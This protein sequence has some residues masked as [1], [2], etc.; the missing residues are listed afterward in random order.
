MTGQP[1]PRPPVT[2]LPADD[3]FTA[4]ETSRRGLSRA[5][6]EDRPRTHGVNGLPR[7]APRAVG[8]QP[9]AQFT[10]LFAVMLLAASGITFL[11]YALEE[12]RDAG[13]LTLAVAILGVVGLNAAIGFAQEY[14]A[15]RTAQALEAMVPHTCRVLRDGRSSATAGPPCR[16]RRCVCGPGTRSCSCRTPPRNTRSTRHSSEITAGPG[17]PPVPLTADAARPSAPPT[18]CPSRTPRRPPLPVRVRTSG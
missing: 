8:R 17:V 3:V 6:A 1:G 7:T 11:A 14:S 5:Q 4:L 13:T 12:P 16:T 10:D 15:E 2:E 18:P 9:A